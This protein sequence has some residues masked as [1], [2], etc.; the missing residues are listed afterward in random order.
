MKYKRTTTAC[1]S[2]IFVQAVI[3]NLVPLLF[4]SFMALYGF[5]YMDLG[6]LIGTNFVTQVSADVL[7][8]GFIDRIGFRKLIYPTCLLSFGG[9]VLFGC[10]PWILPNYI[11]EGMLIATVI[12]S[13]SGGLAEVLIS[14]MVDAIPSDDKVKAMSLMH[15]FYAWGQLATIIGTT[16]FIF[17]FGGNNWQ[18]I[19][20]LWA[21]IP[22][23]NFFL[24]YT[25]PIPSP[26]P[27]SKR[28]AVKSVLKSPFYIFALISIFFGAGAEIVLGQWTSAFM[29]KGLGLTK[30]T[31][32][33]I[34][35]SGYALML[36]I[37]RY[38]YGKIGHRF[39]LSR[40]LIGS[41]ILSFVCYVVAAISPYPALNI[42]ACV[43]CGLGT[44]LL[45]P[46]T[47]SL[48]STRFPM[49]GAWMFAVLS[50]AGDIGCSLS[51]WLTGKL[52]DFT[53]TTSFAQI[54]SQILHMTVEQ[55]AIRIGILCAAV[56][57][58]VTI[59]T[60]LILKRLGEKQANV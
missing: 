41:S 36:G 58:L 51:S 10:V 29:E 15:S 52:V 16:L 49:A 54:L 42:L 2:T 26:I 57:P 25:S 34:G 30:V 14:P 46:G 59:V 5:S 55:T 35:M 20:F 7:F 50:V 33:L 39:N 60:H 17:V 13:F 27:A 47:L 8:S 4:T 6:I 11:F 53:L 19:T 9:L 3:V 56:F 40:V 24:F 31:G 48:S 1:M 21:L 22:F 23:V 38:I 28:L 32:D 43:L 12:F 45:W 37:G 18:I 44:S